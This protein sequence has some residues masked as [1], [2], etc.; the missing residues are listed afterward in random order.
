MLYGAW[1]S[2]LHAH[3]VLR[4]AGVSA[5][6]FLPYVDEWLKHVIVPSLSDPVDAEAL[7]RLDCQTSES[8]L[9][10]N[11]WAPELTLRSSREAGVS[12]ERVV[13]LH[14]PAPGKVDAG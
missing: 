8:N 4:V 6:Q 1:Y 3:A 5:A 9:A 11:Q 14:R 12:P 7:D 13:H 10:V 2:Y